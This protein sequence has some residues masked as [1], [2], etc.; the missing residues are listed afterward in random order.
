MGAMLP[1]DTD[2]AALVARDRVR[3][4]RMP[5]IVLAAVATAGILVIASSSTSPPPASLRTKEVY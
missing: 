2:S 3:S 4:S 1:L 5:L